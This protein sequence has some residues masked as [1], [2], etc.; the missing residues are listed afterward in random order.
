[1]PNVLLEAGTMEC[2]VIGTAVGGIPEVISDG[3][4]GLLVPVED[5]VALAAAID[6][7]LADPELRDR[8]AR[9]HAERVRALFSTDALAESYTKIFTDVVAAG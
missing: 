2:T 9:A 8:F 6:R 1:M 7:Y 3:E 5:D 4:T